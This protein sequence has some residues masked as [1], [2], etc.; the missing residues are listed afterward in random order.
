MIDIE[1]LALLA[2]IKLAPD[3]GEKIQNEF[4]GILGYISKLHEADMGEESVDKTAR[5]S[6]VE[7]VAR[8]DDENHLS[9][10]F[11]EALLKATPT[12]EKG[13]VKVKQILEQK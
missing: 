12:N 2:R 1:K 5:I 3:E 6:G 11:S 8:E 13:Y 10:A 9:G 7:N 4:E